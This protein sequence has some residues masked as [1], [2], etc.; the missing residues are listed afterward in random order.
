MRF[1]PLVLAV[2]LAW[3]AIAHADPS[4]LSNGVFIVHCT[5][6]LGFSSRYEAR[7]RCH[8]FEEPPY[9]IQSCEEQN[10]RL[11][12]EYQWQVWYVVAAWTE[13]K[14]WSGT[15]FGIGACDFDDFYV[16]CS[17]PCFPSEG[18][19]ISSNG[20][21]CPN[22]GTALTVVDVPWQGNFIPVYFF[23]GFGYGTTGQIPLTV[24]P[25]TGFGGFA[26]A[27]APPQQFPATCYGAL[28]C[29]MPGIECCPTTTVPSVCCLAGAECYLLA[30]SECAAMEGVW[31]PEWN[32][33]GPP[34]PCEGGTPVEHTTWGAIK[35]AYR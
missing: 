2:V 11:E 28:G 31:H 26:N 3:A 23:E 24:D 25:M 35:A 10:T 5:P 21:P 33:C 7:D 22:G 32:S 30:E 8:D 9:N 27:D 18:L 15:E 13:E 29:Y 20:W 17:E 6:P 14:I 34:N 1:A 16:A 12:G 4:D 19:E